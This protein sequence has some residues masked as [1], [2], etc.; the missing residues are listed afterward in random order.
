MS[1]VQ[2]YQYGETHDVLIEVDSAIVIEVG[3]FC[4]FNTDDVRNA[5]ALADAGSEADNKAAFS[6]AMIGVSAQAS[7]SGDTDPIRIMRS[8]VFEYP[9]DSALSSE[10]QIFDE[11]EIGADADGCDDQIIEIGSTSPIARLVEVHASGATKGLI[12]IY[13]TKNP[14]VTAS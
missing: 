1:D 14:Y 11:V 6:A 7:A 8:G 13:T 2:R 3:D 9:F 4:Y 12:E 5:A 10:Q